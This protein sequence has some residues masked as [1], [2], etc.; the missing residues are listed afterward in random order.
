[1]YWDKNFADMAEFSFASGYPVVGG[2][3]SQEVWSPHE[4]KM[5]VEGPWTRGIEQALAQFTTALAF[6]IEGDSSSDR[7]PQGRAGPEVQLR[8]TTVASLA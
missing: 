5:T 7:A 1:M 4:L 8:N 2:V 6:A 3:Q